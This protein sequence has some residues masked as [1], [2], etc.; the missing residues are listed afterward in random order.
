MPRDVRTATYVLKCLK[1]LSQLGVTAN[2]IQV[3]PQRPTADFLTR[4][5]PSLPHTT[6]AAVHAALRGSGALD[7]AGY[8]AHDPRG[9][10]WREAIAAT[11]GL[12]DSLPGPSTGVR[13]SLR[14]D[15]SALSE[16]LN[17]AW[18]AHEIVADPMGATLRW[19][20]GRA[21]RDPNATPTSARAHVEEIELRSR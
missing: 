17:V 8:L 18:A 2:Q 5:I 1:R 12:V 3:A 20:A 19:L 6:A 13:D 21:V 7:G 9:S 14:G 16:V 4:H 10:S 15:E 11:P